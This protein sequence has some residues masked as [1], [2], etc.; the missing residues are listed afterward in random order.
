MKKKRSVTTVCQMCGILLVALSGCANPGSKVSEPKKDPLL[1]MV[2]DTDS[3]RITI[4]LKNQSSHMIKVY[5]SR[6]TIWGLYIH[7]NGR[8]Y[9]Y[10][11]YPVVAFVNLGP[12]EH[13]ITEENRSP[14]VDLLPGHHTE[15]VQLKIL[16][17]T[18]VADLD[19]GV[20]LIPKDSRD[21]EETAKMTVEYHISGRFYDYGTHKWIRKR[22]FIGKIKTEFDV[23]IVKV[24][25]CTVPN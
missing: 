17:R 1:L 16:P 19:H 18:F 7:H 9:D 25:F 10:L 3:G 21:N 20:T 6:F 8:R 15:K 5:W 24:R 4:S 14:F 22:C 11:P 2:H 12:S 23:S 13:I